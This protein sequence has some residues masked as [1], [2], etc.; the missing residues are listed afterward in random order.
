MTPVRLVGGLAENGL[1]LLQLP[2]PI[3]RYGLVKKAMLPKI[4]VLWFVSRGGR[5]TAC[6]LIG[7]TRSPRHRLEWS[8]G[9]ILA[10]SH[11]KTLQYIYIN[12]T[13]AIA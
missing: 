12:N 8:F 1:A 6:T 10:F 2:P 11:T 5:W 4:W 7:T 13:H 9:A 3:V